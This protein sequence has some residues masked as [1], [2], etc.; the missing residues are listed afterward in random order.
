M[1][2]PGAGR[3]YR[4]FAVRVSILFAAIFVVAGTNLPYFPVWLDWKGLSPSEI[5]LITALPLFVRVLVTPVIAFAADRTGDHRRFLIAL[6]WC[7][8]AALT[9]LS[10][11]TGFWPI[12]VCTLAFSVAWTTIMPLTET[13]ALSGVSV[14]GLDYGRMRLWGSLT[15][16][17]ASFCGGWVV[18]RHGAASA[19]W[20]VV[21]GGALTTA[22][23]HALARPIGLGRL[24]AATSPPRLQI[25]DAMGLLRSRTILVFLLATGAIQAAHAVFY[26]FGT[27]HW[28]QQGHSAGWSGA[29]WA[30]AV[31][32]EIGLFAFSAAVMRRLGAV[33]LI[34]MGGAAA[35]VRWLAMGFDPPLAWLVPLQILHG[36]T[37][38]A[39]HLGAMHFMGRVVPARQ[40]G[41]AQ[42][43]YASV[44]GGIAMGGAM[45]MAGPLYAAYGGHAYWP[46]AIIAAVGVAAGVLLLVEARQRADHPHS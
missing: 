7:G 37:F 6:S 21:A 13:V 14:A 38:G 22:A 5:A 30:I 12:L 16:I 29:L 40:T 39:T 11:S 36:L 4:N 31:I 8:L 33:E 32:A 42:A 26:T 46:M 44:T 9:L 17:A 24:K 1:S 20:L 28:G 3:D 35:V 10:Q 25:A 18:E 27:L 19:I 45:L 15:F 34:I 2:A 41:T 23:S 43:L